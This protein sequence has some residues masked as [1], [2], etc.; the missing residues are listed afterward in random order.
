MEIYSNVTNTVQ[1]IS[2]NIMLIDEM[3]LFELRLAFNRFAL[4]RHFQHLLQ[5]DT[6][7]CK[8]LIVSDIVQPMRVCIVL[9]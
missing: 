2:L 5:E 1:S 8:W 7:L 9:P 3:N 6:K 4:G